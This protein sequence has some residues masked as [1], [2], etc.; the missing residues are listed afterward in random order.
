MVPKRPGD[1]VRRPV[2]AVPDGG[3]GPG[4][5]E[6]VGRLQPAQHGRHEQRA[7]PI[8]LSHLVNVRS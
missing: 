4:L 2:E 5:E 3:V 6:E 1:D 8:A 7:P